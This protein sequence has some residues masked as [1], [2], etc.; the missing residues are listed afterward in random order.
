MTA[1]FVIIALAALAVVSTKED[2][3]ATLLLPA[4]T[5]IG[6]LGSLVENARERLKK[7]IFEPA[8]PTPGKYL[9]SLFF[10]LGSLVWTLTDTALMTFALQLVMPGKSSALITTGIRSIDIFFAKYFYICAA[11]SITVIASLLIHYI[12]EYMQ[13]TFPQQ[14]R[15]IVAMAVLVTVIGIV[16]ALCSLRYYGANTAFALSKSMN[17]RDFNFPANIMTKSALFS[18]IL[19]AFGIL[20]SGLCWFLGFAS[21]VHQSSQIATLVV[22]YLPLSVLWVLLIIVK[23]ILDGL[24]PLLAIPFQI[25]APVIKFVKWL[26]KKKGPK[27]MLT[28]LMVISACACFQGCSEDKGRVIVAVFD[29]TGSFANEKDN[30]LKKLDEIIDELNLGD[31]FYFAL[32][33]GKSFS[34]KKLVFL[35]SEGS[36]ASIEGKLEFYKRKDELKSGILQMVNTN[37]STRT[38]ISGSLNRVQT[39]FKDKDSKAYSK[40]LLIFS[41]MSDNTS[42]DYSTSALD[43]VHVLVLYASSDKRNYNTAQNQIERWKQYFKDSRASSVEILNHDLSLSFDIQN[44]IKGE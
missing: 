36:E 29:N 11:F 37:K 30:S 15:T 34:D 2:P 28:I 4:T 1:L 35:K 25:I 33:G 13:E 18:V 24:Q 16:V 22:V 43:S 41:D 23:R 12:F 10:L 7:V 32:I 8:P 9:M 19:F 40:Y 5:L 38:D 6:T 27:D 31:E 44:F 17:S 3:A 39:I 14:I 42:K 21:T 26:W 20:A